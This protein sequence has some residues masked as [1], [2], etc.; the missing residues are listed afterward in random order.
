[1]KK[2]RKSA[3]FNVRA[4]NEKCIQNFFVIKSN[5]NWLFCIHRYKCDVIMSE[6]N[7]V[8]FLDWTQLEDIR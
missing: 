1:M 2:N 5:G 3:S 6:S 4:G 8:H 7:I